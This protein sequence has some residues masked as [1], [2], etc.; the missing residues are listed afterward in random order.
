M[1][2]VSCLMLIFI[3]LSAALPGALASAYAVPNQRL[4]L[5]T[6]PNT[7]YVWLYTLPETTA[8][9]AYEYEQGNGVTWVLVEFTYKN[10]VC[11]GYTGL[12]RMTVN[13]NIPWASHLD[14]ASW[15]GEN[16]TVLAAPSSRA[17]YRGQLAQ[18]SQVTIL[19]YENGYAFIEFY[20]TSAGANSRGYLET[21][22]LAGGSP[23]YGPTPAP[24]QL[25]PPQNGGYG[26]NG[27]YG[28]Q[29]GGDPYGNYGGYDRY[30]Y[31]NYGGYDRYPYGAGCP[32]VPNQQL[33]LRTGPSTAYAE[34][35]SMPQNT[36]ITAFE[37]EEGNDVTWVLVEYTKNGQVCRGYT[38]LK[39]MTV[40]GSIPWARHMDQRAWLRSGCTV[41]AAP[42][43]YAAYRTALGPG[44]A[45]TVLGW[46]NG[47]A[48]IEFF[49]LAQ[50]ALNRGYVYSW[51][52]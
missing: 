11:R 45:V 24:G 12:K 40:Y 28:Y 44:T 32:A 17:G 18:G 52:I 23:W 31:G 6:G 41:Y 16:C 42:S 5:R 33:A 20:D 15:T 10:Q 35:G 1:K 2:R 25:T 21:R 30:P 37:Y 13:G 47:Y 46:E 4:A 39:R 9:T 50:N 27:D 48:N 38:G 19:G 34:L 36:Q 26:G 3:L 49:D 29:G 43:S 8:I 7:A 51:A 22:Y 14:Q